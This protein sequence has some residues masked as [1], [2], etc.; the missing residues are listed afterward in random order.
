[1]KAEEIFS[2]SFYVS[3]FTLILKP[4]KDIPRKENYRPK[5]LTNID[6]KSINKLLAR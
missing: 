1:M 4:D 5:S 6:V 3:R 2:N